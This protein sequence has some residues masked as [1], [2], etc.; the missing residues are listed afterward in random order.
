MM[1]FLMSSEVIKH[2][3]DTEKKE[4][5]RENEIDSWGA[6]VILTK[7]KRALRLR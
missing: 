1:K 7:V 6:T 3:E 5:E 2:D 4:S